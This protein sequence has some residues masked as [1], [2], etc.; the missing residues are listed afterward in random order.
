M[1]AFYPWPAFAPPPPRLRRGYGEARLRRASRSEP[2]RFGYD[3]RVTEVL[4]TARERVR[5]VG[6]ILVGAALLAWAVDN[7][8]V[9]WGIATARPIDQTA[10]L[11]RTFR[12]L[13]PYLPPFGEVSFLEPDSDDNPGDPVQL[14][15]VAQYALVPRTVHARP[16]AEFII[17]PRGTIRP[18]ADPRLAGFYPIVTL[19]S[20][21]R[22]YRRLAP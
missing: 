2:T 13:S 16:G 9:T 8:W 5:R 11:D 22:L 19:D 12:S 21:D 7:A 17:V 20:G 14:H 6:P 15:Y 4:T 3:R 18:E 10:A 1:A